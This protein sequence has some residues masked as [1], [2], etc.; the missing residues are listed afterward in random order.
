MDFQ[1][2]DGVALAIKVAAEGRTRTANGHEARAAV[3]L[4]GAAGVD[5]LGQKVGIDVAD[6]KQRAYALQAVDVENP[7]RSA[8]STRAAHEDRAFP[9]AEIRG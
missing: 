7:V 3:P 5:V 1:A 6:I 4:R 8:R 9:K 2:A